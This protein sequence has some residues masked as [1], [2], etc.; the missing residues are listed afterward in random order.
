MHH[1]THHRAITRQDR[2]A[3]PCTLVAAP[4]VMGLFEI[5][6]RLGVSKSYAR[7]IAGRRNF[8]PAT[9]LHQGFVWSTADVEAWIAKHRPPKEPHG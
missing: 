7:E 4:K 8:P 6:E 2:T 3:I 1:G 9:R 5:A